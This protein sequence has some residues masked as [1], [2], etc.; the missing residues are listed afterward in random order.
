MED[1]EIIKRFWQRDQ[2]AIEETE[3]KYSTALR[4]IAENI[5][6]SR[7][8]AEECV[9]DTLL[10][11]WD[12]IPPQKPR[13]LFAYLA[14]ICRFSA[15]GRLD[16]KNAQKRQAEIVELTAEMELCIPNPS[17]ACMLEGAEIG[18]LMNTFLHGLSAEA[19]CVFIRRYWFTDSIHAIAQQY[20]LSESKVKILLFRARKQLKNYLTEEGIQV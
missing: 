12:S 5:L 15:L 2:S 17:D 16:W 13:H 10:K 3:R 9:N 18:E 7:P 1:G 6:K 4:R 11:A 20:Q 14:K 8:D 19:R